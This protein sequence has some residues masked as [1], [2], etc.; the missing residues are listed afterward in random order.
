VALLLAG[1]AVG[2]GAAIGDKRQTTAAA[3]RVDDLAHP[4]GR[5]WLARL[6]RADAPLPPDAP[7]DAR[8]LAA[9]AP[10]FRI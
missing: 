5:D 4:L 7:A 9:A 6:A 8:A 1:W 10:Q 2:L 3:A